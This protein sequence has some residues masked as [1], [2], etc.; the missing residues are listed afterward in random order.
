MET[1]NGFVARLRDVGDGIADFYLGRGLDTGDD[2]AHI[3]GRDGFGRLHIEFEHTDL[4]G[5]VLLAGIEEAYSVTGMHGAVNH[6]VVSNDAAERIE[7]RV[8]DQALERRF[9][10]TLRR[11]D[12]V[13]DG[14]EYLG[15]TITCL[16]RTTQY[17][18]ALTAQQVDDL[19]L[20]EIRHSRLHIALVHDR[21]NLEV[22]VKRHV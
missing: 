14:I 11:R 21:D 7:D 18:F 1:L 4:V 5:V 12:T 16:S 22:M 10:V 19:I 6:F 9:G 2:I 8:E 17:L 3:T 15:H 13:D 20:H